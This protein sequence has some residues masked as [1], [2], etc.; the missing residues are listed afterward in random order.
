[1]SDVVVHVFAAKVTT[2]EEILN[3]DEA[4][5]KRWFK[6]EYIESLRTNGAKDGV[7][8]LAVLYALQFYK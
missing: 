7:S 4:S 8:I 5:D 1:M 6:E 2:E 3:T